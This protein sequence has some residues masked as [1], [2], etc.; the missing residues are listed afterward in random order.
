MKF[1]KYLFILAVSCIL[2]GA[3]SI[4]GLYRYIEPQLPDVATLKDVRLQTPMQ[5]YSADGELIAQFGE[6]RRIPL[7]LDQI[8]PE[9]VH[10]FIATEDSRFYDHHGVDPVGIIRAASIALTSGHA[11]QGASTITQQ[12]ARNFF[13]S[14]E[15]TLI[16][17]IKEVFLAI[18]IEQLLTKDEI[19]ELYLNKIYLGYRAYGVGAAAQVYFGRPVDQLTLS[20]MAMIAGLPKA[21]STFNPLYSYDRAV[22]RRNVVLARM[23]DENYITPSQYDAAR[24]EKLVANYHAPEISFSAPYVA[25]MARQEM[26]KRYGEDAY[27][28][29]YKVY[30]TVTKKLQTAAQDAL[31]NNIL[32]Y[33]MRH[34]YRGPGKV[35]WKV[36]EGVWDQAKMIAALKALPVYGPLSP[37]IVTSTTADNAIAILSDGSNI[38]LPMAGMR[39]ARAYRSDTQQ[40]P[41][42]KRVTD[43]VQTGQQIWVRKVNDD[44]WLAQVPDVNS[45]IV[46]L[47]PKNGAIEALVGGFDFNQSKF[48]RATQALRQIGS[49]IKPFLYTA[50]MDK[51]LT[52]ATILNDVPITRWDA[53]A[54][55]DWRPKNSPAT[56]DGPIR[57]RQGLGQ[58]KNVVMVRAMRAMGVD[59][60]AEYLQRFGFPAQNIVH[61]ESLALGAASFTPLQVVR[62]Y[63]VMANGGYLVDPY[64]ISK[65][66]NEVSGTVFTATPKVVCDTCN[67]PLVYG[68]TPRS[69]VLATTN[70]ED[71][72]T[73]NEAPPL[74]LPQPEL[75][76]VTPE[77]AQQN[78]AQPYAPHVISTPLSFLIKDA[79]NSNVFGEPGW[80]GTGW[81]AG[82]D[83]KR[84]DIGGKT[85]TTNSSKDAWFSGYGPNLVTSVWIGFD[86]H[87][88]DLGASSA[89]GAIKDQISGYEG[90]AK[91]AQPAWDDFMKAALDGVPEQPLTPPPGVV[92]VVIDRSSGK[93]SSGGGNSR[94]EYFVEGTQ[95][96]EYEVHEVGTTLMDNGQSEE[97]F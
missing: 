5:V 47:N 54:G 79:L 62:G 48:N 68:D 28:D 29:G 14:P 11:S 35:L 74:G 88:R 67:L 63:A 76:P 52:L 46:S 78:A 61:T 87:R 53:G 37:A 21:P 69:P 15:R 73:S 13:L 51:G 66:E 93:L 92:S 20:E 27:N 57:L 25:E 50:A 49:N 31:R 55:S 26:F 60:A 83:L 80:M 18:R 42:P 38:A 40:G 4:Y 22:A 70:V 77:A 94:S 39:W 7:K 10:A 91:S 9:L 56:Y 24:N 17:K 81:R 86:D 43:V 2:L 41:T 59:Y 12:L 89:S 96:K 72:A 33:D 19:L 30:T 65:I 36:G 3:A 45:A 85:G 71:V 97:L 64:L 84:R 58:S 1:V 6:K 16:R 82:R 75:E 44:W 32:A 23:K 95:P 8:P 34:G 90:G